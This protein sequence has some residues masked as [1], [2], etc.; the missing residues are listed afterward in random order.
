MLAAIYRTVDRKKESDHIYFSTDS[1]AGIRYLAAHDLVLEYARA[2]HEVIHSSIAHGFE[3][4][5]LA[6]RVSTESK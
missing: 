2:N 1:D 4:R 3:C 6:C 5:V